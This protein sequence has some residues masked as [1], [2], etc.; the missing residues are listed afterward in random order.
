[1]GYY[2]VS[3]QVEYQ[4]P[5]PA[6]IC[7]SVNCLYAQVVFTNGSNTSCC[8]ILGSLSD[9][10]SED[11]FCAL[12]IKKNWTNMWGLGLIDLLI[13]LSNCNS[14]HALYYKI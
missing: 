1:M 5:L 3:V 4:G 13:Y 10:K 11:W 2:T 14:C 9:S 7:H 8:V 12:K 6:L